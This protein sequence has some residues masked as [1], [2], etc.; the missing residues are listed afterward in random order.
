[1]IIRRLNLAVRSTL[2]F[3]VFCLL[4]V[5]LGVTALQQANKLRGVGS[6]F[7]VHIIPAVKELGELDANFSDV[8]FYNSLMR[9]DDEAPEERRRAMADIQ[10]SLGKI[11]GNFTALAGLNLDAQEQKAVALLQASVKQFNGVQS[12]YMALIAAN[13][14]DGAMKLTQAELSTSS[15]AL[16]ER[17][18]ALVS[19]NDERA[20]AYSLK[21][22]T[23]FDDTVRLVIGFSVCAALACIVLAWQYTRSVLSPV[24][25][26]L[27]IAERIANNDLSETIEITGQD[28]MARLL[29]ALATMQSNLCSA[30]EKIGDSS[31]QLAA[32]AEEMHAI[33]EDAA[34]GMERQANEV[35]MAATAVTEMSAAIEE[36]ARNAAGALEVATQTTQA[37]NHGCERVDETLAAIAQMVGR[38]Q[39]TSASVEE[40]A[41]VASEINKVL[42]VIRAVAE[43]TNLLAL[44]AA[45]EAAR[46]GEAGRG[47]AVVAEEVRALARRTQQATQDIEGMM[48][49]IESCSGAALKA[50]SQTNDQALH[51]QALSS[52]AGQALV[53]I[54]QS[55]E[56]IYERSL[57]IA[58]AAEEQAQVAHEVDR[59][60]ISIRDLASQSSE[61]SQ[62]TTIASGELS[63]LAVD[64]S[65]LVKQFK[66]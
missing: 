44:N 34:K 38:V 46:A 23:A 40:L 21:A 13:D 50:M 53:Q 48:T 45:I 42:A 63:Y 52:A 1:M 57:M 41:T 43:Q 24:R 51:T 37:A 10:V 6:Y 59:S 19:S 58:T 2:F 15:R 47:F 11:E 32:T 66:F 62:Q 60:L 9:N 56:H 28:E 26:A 35:E 55:I 54:N 64:L 27:Q 22:E 33:T 18:T 36:V 49:G 3:S 5:G 20:K 30:L 16:Q 7:Q 17:I 31:T 4:I 61:G 29:K 8:R 65:Q 14:L 39:D 12:H 25:Q